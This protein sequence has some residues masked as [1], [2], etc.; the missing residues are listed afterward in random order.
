M[1]FGNGWTPPFSAVLA[2]TL[3]LGGVFHS[4]DTGVCPLTLV[5]Q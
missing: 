4:V 3:T 2:D 1:A 5:R